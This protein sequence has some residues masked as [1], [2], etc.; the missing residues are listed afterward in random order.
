[1][2]TTLLEMGMNKTLM[3]MQIH[4][5]TALPTSVP[6]I[7][8]TPTLELDPEFRTTF[9]KWLA[10]RFGYQDHPTYII[11]NDIFMHPEVFYQLKKQLRDK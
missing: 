4:T 7:E 2:D 1:M 9:N 8:L 11:G 3:G 5:T 6:K 10:D